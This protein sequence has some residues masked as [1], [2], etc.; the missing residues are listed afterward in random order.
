MSGLNQ[1]DLDMFDTPANRRP[2]PSPA[3]AAQD[4]VVKIAHTKAGYPILVC[5]ADPL[6][7]EVIAQ[8][9]RDNIPAFSGREIQLLRDCDADLVRHILAVKREFPGASVQEVINEGRL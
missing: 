4:F 9:Q 3:P 6:P 7:A 5:T 8:G 1:L 2:E